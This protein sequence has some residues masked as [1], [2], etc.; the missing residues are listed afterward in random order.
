MIVNSYD[1][2]RSLL[3]QN[4]KPSRYK[5]SL[6]VADTAVEL[7]RRFGVAEDKARLA[8][9]LHDCARMYEADSFIAEAQKRGIAIGEI[10]M[11]SPLLLHAYVGAYV[12]RE[13]Y[14]ID[15]AEILQA[16]W[17]HTVGSRNMTTLDKIVYFADMIEPSRNYP[18]VK[19][20]RNLAKEADL[21]ECML[22]G[23]TASIIFVAQQ[24]GL[25]H[26]ATI[27][28]RNELL[29]NKR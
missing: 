20:L 26:P 23:L 14:A 2:R 11:K 10:E 7:A 18:E 22:A 9:L 28:A 3:E 27:D 16:I 17:S 8:G 1:K 5:H 13:L 24:G 21:D 4:L 6:G 25:L 29:L 12:A 15:D 19:Y